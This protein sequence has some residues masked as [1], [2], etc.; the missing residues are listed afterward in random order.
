MIL[1]AS[2]N[3]QFHLYELKDGGDDP[4]PQTPRINVFHITGRL[5]F[6][7][8]MRGKPEY[9]RTPDFVLKQPISTILKC[10][11]RSAYLRLR[12][13]NHDSHNNTL[14]RYYH[15]TSS[16]SKFTELWQ[17]YQFVLIKPK[18][19]F[20]PIAKAYS[21]FFYLKRKYRE[22]QLKELMATMKVKEIVKLD[23]DYLAHYKRSKEVLV[24]SPKH[25]RTSLLSKL[26]PLKHEISTRPSFELSIS[27]IH[28][29]RE[30]KGKTMT[31]REKFTSLSK[32]IYS[33]V[34][35]P[36]QRLSVTKFSNSNTKHS[37]SYRKSLLR[38]QNNRSAERQSKSSM[39]IIYNTVEILQSSSKRNI[40][41]D[42]KAILMVEDQMKKPAIK[43]KKEIPRKFTL[44]SIRPSI[45][46][47][48]SSKMR[49]TTFRT[50]AGP[51]IKSLLDTTKHK[52]SFK[53]KNIIKE[54]ALPRH[55]AKQLTQACAV[56]P[57]DQMPNIYAM[58]S[59]R[60]QRTGLDTVYLG[61]SHLN[62]NLEEH[63]NKRKS[64]L[65]P[66]G[67]FDA[68]IL[69]RRVPLY[70]KISS[71]TSH[72]LTQRTRPEVKVFTNTT[73][74]PKKFNII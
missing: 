61:L 66:L 60:G 17:F 2:L 10:N 46:A 67:K 49:G 30:S 16:L 71:S 20:G 22:E 51:K 5:D 21:K 9:T 6:N 47:S 28:P 3:V 48:L 26:K 45:L 69:A 43:E 8:I 58:T 7:V 14:R 15:D 23:P 68:E 57:V 39:E 74:I 41:E 65:E 27:K 50:T 31:I 4:R 1:S 62:K 37:V 72:S 73:I 12:E 53:P 33:K 24:I 35:T 54:P 52:Q 32:I 19:Y 38:A 55:R 13:L 18:I 56:T 36:K 42:L 11:Y 29:A 64:M 25:S 44:N 40:K 70:S 59:S 63:K 34:Q